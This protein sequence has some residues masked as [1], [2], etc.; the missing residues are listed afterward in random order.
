L[1]IPQD[2]HQPANP[3]GYQHNDAWNGDPT[4]VCRKYPGKEQAGMNNEVAKMGEIVGDWPFVSVFVAARNEEANILL[5]LK[6][7]QQQSYP[8]K[9]E[10]L[11]ADDHSEDRTSEI[12]ENAARKDARIH[13]F[14]VPDSTG[15]IQGKALALAHMAE[16]AEGDVFLICDADMQMPPTWMQKMVSTLKPGKV[17][18]VNGTTSTIG[19]NWFSAFQAIDWLLPQGTF[20][21]L[22]QLGVTYTAMGNN[23]GITRKA[24]EATGGYFQIPFSLTEDFELFKKA[25]SKGFNLIHLY[26]SDVFGISSPQRSP[27]DWL[28]QHVRW[29]NGFAQL[30]LNQ[31][32]VFYGQLLFYPIL[33]LSLFSSTSELFSILGLIWFVKLLYNAALLSQIKQFHLL[34][35]LPFYEIIFWPAY[36]TCWLRFIFSKSVQWKGRSWKKE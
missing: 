30:P 1:W 24:Y 32:W 33:F 29:M 14:V 16:R 9:W 26:N 25:R 17:D 6:S 4:Y 11:V 3:I 31:Q 36:F 19:D 5:C 18:L 8:G 22:S 27:L 2:K 13:P 28:N 12:A 23:M 20:A 15:K 7:L 10:V 34:V 21:W 35:W